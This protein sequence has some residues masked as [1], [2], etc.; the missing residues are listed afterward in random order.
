MVERFQNYIGG[1]FV[2]AGDGRTFDSLDPYAGS[3]WAA[4]PEGSVED[5]DHAVAAARSALSGEWGKMTGSPRTPS[6][7]RGSRCATTASS[8]AR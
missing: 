6:G 2:D 7:W 1:K 3:P 5:I 8:T 4:I